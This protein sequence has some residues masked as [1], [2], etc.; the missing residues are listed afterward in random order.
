MTALKN[1]ILSV[2]Y[3]DLFIDLDDR[4]RAESIK[5]FEMI[6]DHSGLAKKRAREA[7]GQARFRMW[8]QGFEEVCTTYGAVLLDGG[9]MPRTDKRVFQ[10]FMRFVGDEGPSVILGLATMAAPGEL[11]IKNKSRVAAVTVNY[12]LSPRLSFDGKGPK[13]DDIFVLLLAARDRERGGKI[14]E[15]AVGIIDSSYSA[16]LFYE[17]LEGFLSSETA[18]EAG[19][20]S[21]VVSDEA[22]APTARVKL[23]GRVIPF[24]P[25]E[26]PESDDKSTADD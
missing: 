16:Y 7:E 21:S 15:V 13:V 19:D 25:P 2:L 14:E 26:H 17:S 6:R 3:R 18:D 12:D 10:P 4:L 11:P 20:S 23:K 1:Y 5:A 8:E 22:I 24:K 9:V